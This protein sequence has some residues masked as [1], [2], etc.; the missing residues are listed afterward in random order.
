MHTRSLTALRKGLAFSCRKIITLSRTY[1]TLP[2][3]QVCRR[4]VRLFFFFVTAHPATQLQWAGSV[5]HDSLLDA[6]LIAMLPE[7]QSGTS[8]FYLIAFTN[9]SEGL[10]IIDC[11]RRHTCSDCQLLDS[12]CWTVTAKRGHREDC[13]AHPKGGF[14]EGLQPSK[15]DMSTA[16]LPSAWL[17][18]AMINSDES[19]HRHGGSDL[20]A[21]PSFLRSLHPDLRKAIESHTRCDI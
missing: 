16:I 2:H 20:K 1:S 10:F 17:C 21:L 14:S 4:P 12:H 15:D 9:R 5:S 3:S 7:G 8:A 6:L 18:Q 19:R 13:N 11:S